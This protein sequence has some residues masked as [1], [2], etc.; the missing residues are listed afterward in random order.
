VVHRRS[1]LYS[2]SDTEF[3]DLLPE[4]IP[5]QLSSMDPPELAAYRKILQRFFTAKSV[6]KSAD[7][8]RAI[9]GM[10][11]DAAAQTYPDE[12]FNFHEQIAQ[13]IPFMATCGLFQMPP[14][15]AQ[16]LAEQLQTLDYGG[17]DPLKAFTDAVITFF[18]EHTRSWSRGEN[19]SLICA[20]MDAEIDGRPIPRADA[21]AYLWVL[22]VGAL[23]T[24]AHSSSIGLLSLFHHPDQLIRLK[25]DFALMPSAVT[26]L[27][28]WTSSSNVVKHMVLADTV[29]QGV[30]LRKGDYVATFPPSANRDEKAFNDPYRFDVGR[31]REAPVFTF[32]GG[33]HLCLGHQFARMEMKIIFEEL[34]RRFPNIEQAGPAARGQAFTMVLSPL[35]ELPV[36]LG[37]PA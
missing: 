35:A 22:F 33:P 36:R 3:M 21:L 9:V 37:A 12:T 31:G 24:V 16:V 17:T 25:N 34:L 30:Q 15:S 32:G 28:R 4:D 5:Y 2:N 29:L 1:E 7:G 13:R 11:L 20:I 26:E 6:E 18:D 10:V 19:E 27:L 8:I 23:D 14:E